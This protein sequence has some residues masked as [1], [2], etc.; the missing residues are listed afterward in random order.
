MKL[1]ITV[2]GTWNI[3]CMLTATN[4]ATMWNI[5]FLPD[6]LNIFRIYP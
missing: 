2:H 5:E 1:N 3:V 6:E 4:M